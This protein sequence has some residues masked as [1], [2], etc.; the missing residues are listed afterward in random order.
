MPDS[1]LPLGKL[2]APLLD[3][4]L[5]RAPVDDPSV[6]LGP[7]V[8]LDC[9]VI[10]TDGELLV[11]KSDPITFVTSELGRYLVQVNGN[12]IATTGATARWLLVTLLLPEANT[13]EALVD[14]LM[15]DIYASCR[16]QGIAVVGGHTEITHGLDRPIAVAALIGTVARDKLVTPRGARP[17]DHLL[18]T[19]TVP[20]EGTSILARGFAQQLRTELGEDDLHQARD[21]LLEPGISVV[22]DAQ[23]ALQAGEVTAMHDPTEGGL[24]AA[25]WELAQA[26]GRSLHVDLERVPV[27]DLSARVCK[28][29]GIDPLATIASGSLLLSTP[30]EHVSSIS[31]ALEAQGIPCTDIGTVGPGPAAVYNRSQDGEVLH[32]RPGRDEIAKVFEG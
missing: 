8:G 32:P 2:P 7:G 1:T 24:V 16:E 15:E 9:A 14:G 31:H 17:A 27:S 10:D 30:V 29:F 5:Q 11:M 18:L 22:P 13:T 25:L 21:Y 4:L 3:R 6:L 28:V 19:K 12:D 26:S 20:I 23:I